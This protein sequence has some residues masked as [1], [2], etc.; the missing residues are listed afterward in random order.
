M[1]E[2]SIAFLGEFQ[3]LRGAK[4]DGPDP[5]T[6]HFQKLAQNSGWKEQM[7]NRW[8]NPL[9]VNQLTSSLQDKKDTHNLKPNVN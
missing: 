9:R 8:I 3:A 5:T 2:L 4:Q 1:V 7:L 6:F